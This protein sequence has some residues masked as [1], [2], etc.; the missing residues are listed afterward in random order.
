MFGVLTRFA[1][2]T[3]PAGELT[4]TEKIDILKRTSLVLLSIM[5]HL[6]APNRVLPY[7]SSRLL[8]VGVAVIFSEIFSPYFRSSKILRVSTTLQTLRR[9]NNPPCNDY[10]VSLLRCTASYVAP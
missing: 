1:A 4:E 2:E 10:P 3:P 5:L 7:L 9:N 8:R 6:L